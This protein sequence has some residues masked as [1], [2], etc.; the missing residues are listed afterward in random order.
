[1]SNWHKLCPIEAIPVQGARVL[2]RKSANIAVFRAHDDTVFAIVD[3]C[4]HKGGPLSA[5]IMH[6][7][8]VTCPLHA[9]NI[10][11]TSGEACSPDAGCAKTYATR[12]DA[13]VVWLQV[14]E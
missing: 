11:L 10:D 6:G 7:H 2:E 9:W 1:M 4:P 5:G 14:G 13:G 12:V 3:E 8:K